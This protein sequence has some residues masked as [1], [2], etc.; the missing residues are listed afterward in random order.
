MPTLYRTKVPTPT[1]Y[2]LSTGEPDDP[3][4][5]SGGLYYT[6]VAWTPKFAFDPQLDLGDDVPYGEFVTFDA[7]NTDIVLTPPYGKTT[8]LPLLKFG[9]PRGAREPREPR[10]L[11]FPLRFGRRKKK[12]EDVGEHIKEKM[13]A[14]LKRARRIIKRAEIAKR[15]E[16]A[17]K[18]KAEQAR[19][20]V[21]HNYFITQCCVNLAEYYRRDFYRKVAHTFS[22]EG[23]ECFI[24]DTSRNVRLPT[25]T[26]LMD[27]IKKMDEMI[28]D[29]IAVFSEKID[30]Q[31]VANRKRVVSSCKCRV[32]VMCTVAKIL[33]YFKNIYHI[34][35]NYQAEDQRLKKKGKG[36][37][38]LEAIG[39]IDQQFIDLY[40]NLGTVNAC[41]DLLEELARVVGSLICELDE[42]QNIIARHLKYSGSKDVLFNF[43]IRLD[44]REK[45]INDWCKLWHFDVKNT[46]DILEKYKKPMTRQRVH[47][48]SERGLIRKEDIHKIERPSNESYVQLSGKV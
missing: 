45:F 38:K 26:L 7:G 25:P 16:I 42:S 10:E 4:C 35:R 3:R 11:P 2:A 30:E 47:E 43:I 32:N 12:I 36:V 37:N 17:M 15:V 14:W 39:P 44:D 13:H 48:L 8:K 21:M 6:P 1:W 20:D 33:N 28:S 19:V 27:P 31:T 41:T 46:L 18:V 29:L 23:I 22:R 9:R 34:H 24:S 40:E 5:T